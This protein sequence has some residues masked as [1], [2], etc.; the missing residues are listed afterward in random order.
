MSNLPA[1]PNKKL[2]AYPGIS[3]I[4]DAIVE[5]LWEHEILRPIDNIR[6]KRKDLQEA[7]QMMF[8]SPSGLEW[9]REYI[10]PL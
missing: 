4:S 1:A 5:H 9:E 6:R 10:G 3:H 8:L 2:E 7:S